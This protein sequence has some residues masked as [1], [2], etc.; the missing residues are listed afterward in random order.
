[1]T[2]SPS[3]QVNTLFGGVPRLY[4]EVDEGLLRHPTF[5]S[6]LCSFAEAAGID[7]A[8]TPV[9]VCHLVARRTPCGSSHTVLPSVAGCEAECGVRRKAGGLNRCTRYA[10][11]VRR[12]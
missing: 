11:S 8:T 1:M 7:T 6:A 3:T 10:R 12:Q 4:E 9:M 5:K 2:P